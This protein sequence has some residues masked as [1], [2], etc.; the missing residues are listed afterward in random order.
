MFSGLVRVARPPAHRV[1]PFGRAV[2]LSFAPMVSP[3][4]A[5][6]ATL[7]VSCPDRKGIVAALAQLLYGH[8]A[9]IIDADQH[10]DALAAS[11]LSAHRRRPVARS[12]PTGSPSRAPS[13]TSPRASGCPIASSTPSPG[14]TS[15]SSSPATA[16]ACTICSL[17]I[18]SA[19]C[20]ATIRLVIANHP[21]LEEATAP[22][23][24]PFH[25]VPVLPDEK[26]R[27]EAQA[28]GLLEEHA[29]DLVVFARYMQ[30]VSP[31][32]TQR[33]RS[34]IINIHHSFLP[35]FVG[36]K[37]YHQAQE[38]GVKLIGATAHYVTPRP[39]RGPHHRAGRRAH[40]APRHRRGS[41]PQGARPRE[42]RA[43]ARRAPAP[44]GPHPGLRKQDGRLRLTGSGP[45]S[46]RRPKRNRKDACSVPP[47]ASN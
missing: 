35:A 9:N 24:V 11:V 19:S 26:K 41:C 30:I 21:D 5:S 47:L 12:T 28:L 45:C 23:G 17:A 13:T 27:A 39:R 6:V 33:Y 31:E 15:P 10:T 2:A 7:L 25:V 36:A 16:T 38:R 22:F 29:I 3:A 34:R 43:R 46:Q 37:P 42:G 20:R 14:R 1:V 32:F 44:R 4:P 18:A 40:L 8:G